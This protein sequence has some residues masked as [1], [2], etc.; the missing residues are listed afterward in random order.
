MKIV[1]SQLGAR[2]HFAVPRNLQ[3]QGMLGHLFTDFSAAK[4][5]LSL[6]QI[7]PCALRPTILQR[8]ISRKPDGVPPSRTTAFSWFGL[9]YSRRLRVAVTGEERD[10]AFLWAGQEFARR[11]IKKGFGNPTAIYAFNTAS[12]ELFEHARRIGVKCILEQTISPRKIEEQL[13]E[14]ERDTFPAWEPPKFSKYAMDLASREVREWELADW[15][16]CASEYVKDGIVA[17]GGAPEKCLIVPYGVDMPS[18]EVETRTSRFE[19][20]EAPRAGLLSRASQPG[21]AA[22]AA[23]DTT[24]PAQPGVYLPGADESAPP[25]RTT[26]SELTSLHIRQSTPSDG[27]TTRLRVLTVGAVGLRKGS[28]Y[29]LAAAKQLKGIAE[30]RMVG[31]IHASSTAEAEI[32]QWIDLAGIVPRSGMTEQYTWADV[33]LLPSLCEGSATSTYEA[34]AYGLPVITTPNAGSVAR[35]GLEGF[36]VPARDADAIVEKLTLLVR[37]RELLARISDNALQLS[38]EYTLKK[39]GDRLIDALRSHG[40]V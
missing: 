7:I 24:S 30:F 21:A 16:L 14:Q 37:D 8:L 17:C 13:M 22:L 11:I 26:T 31:A 35:D 29:V 18:G 10:A 4:G 19:S 25:C 33:F 28:P 20:S 1:V 36:I 38:K 27:T 34:L 15:I 23:A 39:Y 40:V 9:K 5:L 6:L 32:R 3:Q 2:M 12:L